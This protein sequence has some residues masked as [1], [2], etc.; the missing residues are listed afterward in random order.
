M[1]EKKL[2]QISSSLFFL[3]FLAAFFLSFPPSLFARDFYWEDTERITSSDSRFPSSVS[4]GKYTAV[5]WQEIDTAN[6]S[7]WLSGQVYEG[8]EVWHKT[9]R[10]AGP[11]SY[12]GEVPDLYSAVI[13]PSGKIA[14]AVLSDVH[15]ISVFVS[16]DGGYSFK[17]TDLP[18]QKQPLVAPRLYSNSEGEF[19]LFTALGQNEAFS[20]LHSRSRDGFDW[21]SFEVFSPAQDFTNPFIPVLVNI[22]G[23][24]M[25]V[26]Q[27]QQITGTRLSYQLYSTVFKNGAWSVPRI[28]TGEGSL[29]A[30]SQGNYFNYNNQRP[31]L[32]FHER[33][34]FVAWERTY[35]SSEN[36][37]IWVRSLD[38]EGAPLDDLIEL[39]LSGN[40]N[41]PVFFSYEGDLCVVWFDTRSGRESVFFAQKQ[42]ALWNEI[43]L[44]TGRTS[45]G[46]SC[47]FAFP[48]ITD[49][50]STL[51]FIWQV[52][53]SSKNSLPYISRLSPDRT[54][55]APSLSGVTFKNGERG[56]FEDERVSVRLPPDS[57]G[58]AGFSWIWTQNK[59]EMP[60]KRIMRLPSQTTVSVKASEDDTWYFRAR[61][62]DYAGNWS[63][64]AEITYF[65][66][67]TPPKPPEI[68]PVSKD[69]QG[70]TSSE[71]LV[72]SW[73][74]DQ[75]D[76][77]V[78]G[79]TWSLE[80]LGAVEKR[81]SS[82][83]GHPMT[84]D[85]E[86]ASLYLS[87]LIKRYSESMKVYK[88]PQKMLG[89]NTSVTYKNIENGLYAFSVSAVDTVGNI[90]KP[91]VVLV[92]SNKFIP[93]TLISSVKLKKTLLGNSFL[94]IHGKG[95]L[96]DGNITQV[97]VDKDGQ[98]PYDYVYLKS[99][100]SF[101]VRSDTLIDDLD[102]GGEVS[103][104][105]YRIGLVHSDR[106]LYFSR[107]ILN[108]E[109]GGTVKIENEYA[110]EPE[111]VPLVKKT[112]VKIRFER[113]LLYLICAFAVLG[114]LIAV[115]G[116]VQTARETVTIRYEVN[117]LLTGDLMTLEKK[118]RL[119][120]AKKRSGSLRIKLMAFT[121]LLVLMIVVLVAA[122]LGTRMIR[123]QGRLLAEGLES[124][125]GVLLNSVN[126]GARAYL[127]SGN[128]LELSY[129]PAQSRA[130]PEAE[131]VTITGM[132]SSGIEKSLDFVWATNDPDI[133]S[134]VNT[135]VLNYGVSK[136]DEADIKTIAD[137]CMRLN[138]LAEQRIGSTAS[139]IASLTSEGVSLALRTDR[140]S[141]ARREE[142][143][144]ITTQLNSRI[145]QMLDE[146]SNSASSSFPL[147]DNNHLDPFNTEYLFYRPVLYRQ[148]NERTYVHGIVFLKVSTENLLTAVNTARRS[149]ILSAMLVGIFAVFAGSVGAFILATVIV[150]PIRI[151][152]RHVAV[153][154]AT[155]DKSKLA[156]EKIEF[157]SDD[158]IGNLR[159]AV[160]NMTSELAR[161]ALEEQLTLDGRAVQQAFLPLNTNSEGGKTTTS[162]LK[163]NA[164]E[165]FGYYEGAS[166][167]SG[168]YFDYKKLDDR[169]YVFIKCDASGHGVP[170][171]LIMT[172]VATFF[173]RY[174]TNWN[175]SA[176]GGR[177]NELISQI[178]DFIESLGLK[179]KFAAII[180]CLVDTQTGTVYM[181]NAGDNIVHIYDRKIQKLK[182]L[183]LSAAPA[184]GPMPSFMVDMKGGFTVDKTVLEK[185]DI[186]FLYTDG[187]EESTRICR[188]DSFSPL[189]ITEKD[190]SGNDK[191][192]TVTEL[193]EAERVKEVIEAVMSKKVFILEKNKNPVPGE[194]LSFDFT[195]CEGTVEEAIT[196][197]ISV[198]KIFRMYKPHGATEDDIVKVDRNID[199]FLR[200]HFNLY[201]T[202]CSKKNESAEDVTYVY[203]TNVMED[204]QL[205]DLTLVAIR[206]L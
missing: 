162:V 188:D 42:G 201:N 71:N 44:S 199:K 129:L 75:G 165:T 200:L 103:E 175:F 63:A 72:F 141:V 87:S 15:T 5:F 77:D 48:V 122:S 29:L 60:P 37:H 138:D 184:A 147:F 170:A 85:A 185:G 157:K 161:A 205:D 39:T 26:F 136:L 142:I 1:T 121:I 133:A 130:L 127:P 132:P 113:I 81:F 144:T 180:L 13:Q 164:L 99:E 137:S 96:Y 123:S 97:Y 88:I 32:F 93:F 135:D 156:S 154:G 203:Y 143:S 192:S 50:K 106:G 38:T 55:S 167:V 8:N 64:P 28:I 124:R 4:N 159:D 105:V 40:A 150:R 174:F 108:V 19:V 41:R 35:Y 182:T 191:V 3:L 84:A 148:G 69:L 160:N 34:V 89:V 104:G 196:A 49:N 149:I 102:L 7:I 173:R 46:N 179:G 178:N 107:A 80:R 186:L 152:E 17:S 16:E 139:Q 27:A 100:N 61:A 54:V 146:L 21:Q 117:A 36:S 187:I 52:N 177:L 169:W 67:T 9:E 153:I 126:T 53:P 6:K 181:S 190:E 120:S 189:Q 145:T 166:G 82:Y 131:F 20:M 125:I 176:N 101:R 115:R 68:L 202:Y 24:D 128:I 98:A 197:L 57:S 22:P 140:V 163:D 66:D 51:S 12:S 30:S 109:Q 70:F 198:E 111:W 155:R 119:K 116:I 10:F 172:V 73:Q 206:R 76:G 91:S 204:E 114:S 58:I 158:E 45:S 112:L 168:D 25:V 2:P 31:V 83:A 94:E 118:K 110:Y 33:K 59:E 134:K 194:V 183:T 14:L 47:V 78:S 11:F 95:F 171:A 90:G 74:A 86:E 23:G 92:A 43:P 18:R 56:R 151:L 195:T 65:K 62:L 193:L 79:Y